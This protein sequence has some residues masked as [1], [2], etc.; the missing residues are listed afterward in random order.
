MNCKYGIEH[1]LV[2]YI[3][4]IF[5]KTTFSIFSNHSIFS[6]LN[7]SQTEKRFSDGNEVRGAYQEIINNIHVNNVKNLFRKLYFNHG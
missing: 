2:N 3:K 6:N 1:G 4:Q 5:L 7:S